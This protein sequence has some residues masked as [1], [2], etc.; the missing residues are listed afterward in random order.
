MVWFAG[1]ASRYGPVFAG[2]YHLAAELWIHPPPEVVVLGARDHP[3]ASA[4]RRA[5]VETFAPGKTV[6][7]VDKTDAYVH[8]LVVPM[9]ATKEA[10]AGP[11][12]FV[13]HG[14]VCSP[15]T[16]DAAP[17]ATLLEAPSRGQPPS[18]VPPETRRTPDP[19]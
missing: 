14:N 13:C 6:L 3:R 7:V 4:L 18:R 12:A 9:R 1:D 2:T 19:R 10:S 5:A 15:P 16:S 11:L 17:G 8:A